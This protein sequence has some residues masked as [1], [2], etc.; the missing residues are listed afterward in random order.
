MGAQAPGSGRLR[1]AVLVWLAAALAIILTAYT[2]LALRQS[3]QTLERSAQQSAEALVESL[4]LA[5]RNV[6][7][8][9]HALDEAWVSRWLDAARSLYHL[10][11]DQGIPASWLYDY[12]TP[13]IDWCDLDGTIR[14]ST[15]PRATGPLPE[16]LLAD[17]SWAAIQDGAI[18]AECHFASQTSAAMVRYRDRALILWGAAD[19]LSDF[20]EDIG[21]G[22]LI[23][24]ISDLP[25]LE[26]IVLPSPGGIELGSRGVADMS[27]ISGDPELARLLTTGQVFS[28]RW[29]F[30]EEPVIEA[31]ARIPD[32]QRVLR[33]GVSR[34]S[35]AQLD[36][37][38]TLQ[39]SLLGGLLFVLGWGGMALFFS[40]QRF[41]SLARELS[42][43]EALTD[44][45]FRGIRAALLVVD[46]GG[47]IRLANPPAG[48]LLGQP[49]ASLT[50]KKYFDVAPE[51]PARLRPLLEE[52]RAALEQ[53]VSWQD[54]Q[55]R[56]RVLLVSNSLLREP[57]SD[58]VAIVH[59]VTEARRL[60][61]QAEQ[62]ER[63]AAMGDLAAG[64]A[65]EVR[66]PLNAI[67]IAAQRLAVE[68]EPAG[69][70]DEYRQ[71][72]NNLRREID[73]VNTTVQEFLGLARGI[74]LARVPIDPGALVR[75]AAENLSL[76]ASQK[77][78]TLSVEAATIPGV[79]GDG[80]AL[81]KV[82]V[83]LVQNA[84][85]ATSAGGTVRVRTAVQE[86]EAVLTVAD[87][88][89]GIAPEDIP[90]L[91]RPYFSRREGGSG[92]GLALVHRIVT[93]H[94][95]RIEVT[96]EPGQGTQFI[97]RLPIK[98]SA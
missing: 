67:G 75:R 50:G 29:K 81:L 36:Q 39:L 27:S 51:D 65:H 69:Q 4:A 79:E 59:D 46:Q 17:S 92:L 44:E 95:G 10:M 21:A 55:G 47:R 90:H 31:A 71:L 22:Y 13:R 85:H 97:V 68:F 98:G 49:A 3:R 19:R 77:G 41:V 94:G 15:D 45:L 42:A 38:I 26:Y 60:A 11:P 40:S 5:I 96:S 2:L 87:S 76:E 9:G 57:P 84:L 1:P 89:A 74:T 73:R 52:G 70:G 6:T 86:G 23:R 53:D 48:Y 35:L 18:Y 32:Q 78:V 83:N 58:A 62:N 7:T 54:K 20:Q 28:R 61:K 14:L 56:T 33:I 63:L 12:D 93:E 64:V 34:R 30:N 16:L 24:S 66:N 8:A 72:L 37:S 43:A 82:I 25:G 80:E 88:G 91:F